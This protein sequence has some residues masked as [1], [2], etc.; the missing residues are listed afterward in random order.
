MRGSARGRNSFD[1][2]RGPGSGGDP[3]APRHG[4]RSEN[5]P[6]L[7]PWHSG[8]IFF[9]ADDRLSISAPFVEGSLQDFFFR[10][11]YDADFAAGL[12]ALAVGDHIQIQPAGH[13][14]SGV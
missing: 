14:V 7:E 6:T 11:S 3:L 1:K 12:V 2:S 9:G 10:L 8:W 4:R 5:Q 13:R